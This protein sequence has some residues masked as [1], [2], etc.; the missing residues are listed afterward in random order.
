MEL[1]VEVKVTM[2]MACDHFVHS[3]AVLKLDAADIHRIIGYDII[4]ELESNM[5][6]AAHKAIHE[7]FEIVSD[8]IFEEL[9]N[10]MEDM[11]SG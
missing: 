7:A 3:R 6:E 9:L 5:K 8:E 2:H 4:Q 10:I 11:P 1:E